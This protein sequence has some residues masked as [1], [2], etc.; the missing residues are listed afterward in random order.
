M[1]TGRLTIV[2][3]GPAGPELITPQTQAALASGAP[4]WLRTA[5]HPAAVA[6]HAPSFDDV[7]E[8]GERFADVYAEICERLVAEV[9]RHGEVVY[10]VP[11]S[12][13]VL[14]RTVARLRDRD[15]VE[16]EVLPAVS[17]LDAVWARLGIDPVEAGV[18]LVDGHVFATAAAGH[19]GPLLVAHTHANHVLSDL[20]L[21][22]E[23]PP[24]RA[25]LLHHLGL[26]DEQIL[27]VEWAEIDRTI[28]ADHLTSLYV[29]EVAEPVAHE[30]ARFDELVRVLRDECPWDRKQT[31]ASLRQHLLEETHEVLEALDA[32]AELDDA[33][34]D[35]DLD[36]HLVEELGDLLYQ[37][38]F[39]ARLAA[40]RG[41]FT[42]SDVAR[43]VHDKLVS[44]HPHVFGDVVADDASTVESNWEAIKATEKQRTSALDGIPPSLPGLA[45]AAKHQS[46]AAKA[47]FDW[48]GGAE[49]AY[50]D[51]EAELAEV[52]ED[53]SEH[54]VGDLLFAGV[55]VARRL[56]VDPESALRGAVHRYAARFRVVEELAGSP[57]A[58][59]EADESQLGAW[60]A[61][62]K[63]RESLAD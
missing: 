22:F 63:S 8:A 57:E 14:E 36:D 5:R 24:P 61:M 32:R 16:V 56:Q 59:A 40:E 35:A 23:E 54:E 55:Q 41:S 28:E 49:V 1:A 25:V 12:P 52:R 50:A 27:E 11:G 19:V 20:K 33:D 26:P 43:G 46:R 38:F 15:D 44:R 58:L 47:G 3:L 9:E 29:P 17:F 45:L 18:R 42:V 31:H 2:G 10:A 51:V 48:D 6:V 39:H 21:A 37:I 7:Y 13:L 53:P 30:F 34:L 60:W 62:A 4:V